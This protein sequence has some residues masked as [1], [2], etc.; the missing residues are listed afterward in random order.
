MIIE[1]NIDLL[2][3]VAICPVEITSFKWISFEQSLLFTLS[4]NDLNG[5][6]SLVDD[7]VPRFKLN[8]FG[9][10]EWIW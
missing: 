4:L 3:L 2:R 10:T 8:D 1:L 6:A 5:H 7:H 9:E